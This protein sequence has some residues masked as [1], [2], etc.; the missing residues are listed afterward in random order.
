MS[1]F[2]RNFPA[3]NDGNASTLSFIASPETVVGFALTGRLDVD[4]VHDPITTDDGTE[5][6]LDPPSAD[7]L[8]GSGFDAGESGFI[9]PAADGASVT[10]MVDP[11]SDRL[12]LLEPFPA[13]DGN[14]YEGLQVLLKAVGKC[15]TDHI[16]PAGKWLKFRGHLDNISGNLFI[17]V[18]NAFA[19][20]PAGT[21]VDASD[22]SHVPLPDLAR[23][24]KD[25]G[26]PWVAMCSSTP[27]T[28]F[29]L[30]RSPG[31]C[32]S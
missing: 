19:L 16:S 21:G 1:S 24:Y 4:F 8:P 23:R 18:N 12:E 28:R 5:V 17:G 9:P 11:N 3:R 27:I 20:D 7:E 30:F 15:T 32:Q 13:W 22:G 2:N 26:V 31:P 29:F 10:V 14:D 6:Q 25:R